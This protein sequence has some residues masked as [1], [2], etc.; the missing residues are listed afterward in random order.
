MIKILYQERDFLVVEKPSGLMTHPNKEGE[1]ALSVQLVAQFPELK[2]VG[3]DPL[4]P[5][6]VHRLDKETSGVIVI[7]RTNAMY[8]HIR[9]QFDESKVEKEYVAL[10][11][12]IV[13]KDHGIIDAP[14]SRSSKGQFTTGQGCRDAIT[15][16]TVTKRYPLAPTPFTLLSLHPKNHNHLLLTV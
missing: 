8:N 1:D 4:R 16:Y 5:G 12:G 9:K 10:V 6:I 11:Y 3:P 14:L 2:G 7:A 15:E 13:T